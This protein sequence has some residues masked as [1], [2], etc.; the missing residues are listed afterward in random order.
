MPTF[1]PVSGGSVVTVTGADFLQTMSLA[2]QFGTSAVLASFKSNTQ[3]EC[4]SPASSAGDVLLSVANNNLDF[5]VVGNFSFFD[6]E[7]ISAVDIS[8]GTAR[9][10]IVC[11]ASG[12]G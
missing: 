2:C 5:V 4:A 3:I 11:C 10:F 6:V 9:T 1:G 12:L 7:T 8:S